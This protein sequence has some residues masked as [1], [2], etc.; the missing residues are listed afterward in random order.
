MMVRF[1]PIDKVLESRP[2]LTAVAVLTLALGISANTA[3]F[4]VVNHLL[5][6]LPALSQRQSH[7]D[8]DAGEQSRLC[9]L[10]RPRARLSVADARTVD[11]DDRR[12]GSRN[13]AGAAGRDAG[14]HL[15]RGDH[16]QLSSRPRCGTRARTRLHAERRAFQRSRGRD[17]QLW[18]V[19][20][21]GE[22]R[23]ARRVLGSVVHVNGNPYTVVGVDTT[24]TRN[25]GVSRPV[26]PT[27]WLPGSLQSR[28]DGDWRL[29]VKPTCS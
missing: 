13:I 3:I 26:R 21:R 10:R 12:R 18:L 23:P 15:V 7:R 11:R 1:A 29:A 24:R 17:G 5:H 22:G 28:K 16:I 6:F 27:I 20:A 8:A 14:Q 19:A 25:T 4:T 2:D 9:H